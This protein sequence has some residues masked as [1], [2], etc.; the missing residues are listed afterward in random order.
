MRFSLLSGTRLVAVVGTAVALGACTSYRDAAVAS[1]RPGAYV[2][3]KPSDGVPLTVSGEAQT[4]GACHAR[5]VE[6]VVAQVAGADIRLRSTRR[7]NPADRGL[8]ACRSVLGGASLVSIADT[9]RVHVTTRHF[10][11]VK[12]TVLVGGALS[13]LYLMALGAAMGSLMSY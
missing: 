11:G 1:L 10:S 12:T 9:T 8:E 6:G 7:A 2:R 13:V 4:N 3:L 5:Q